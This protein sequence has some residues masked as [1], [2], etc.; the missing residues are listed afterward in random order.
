MGGSVYVCEW[1]S[2]INVDLLH[3]TCILLSEKGSFSFSSWF[4]ISI[5]DSG[6]DDEG[7]SMAG[8]ARRGVAGRGAESPD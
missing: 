6:D 8:T 5:L 3:Y 7:L 4:L 2:Y 1:G